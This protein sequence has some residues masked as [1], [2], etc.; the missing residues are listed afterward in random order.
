MLP[1]EEQISILVH[2][3]KADNYVAES[4]SALIHSIGKAGGLKRDA[5]ELI[6]DNPKPIP[7]LKNLPPD[8]KFDYIF[9]VIQLMKIDGK[10]H[11]KEISF[12]E[13]L[14]IALGYK[15]GVVADLSAYIYSDPSIQ[16]KRSYLRTIADSHLIPMR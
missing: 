3:S 13:R 9:N 16:T 5:V 14:A 15:P 10:I 7:H 12:C 4:E 11:Q 6:M 2:L 1:L 8:E